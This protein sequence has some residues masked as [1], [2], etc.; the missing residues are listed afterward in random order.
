MTT[1]SPLLVVLVVVV[2]VVVFV[3]VVLLVRREPSIAWTSIC[4]PSSL[5]AVHP[6][7]LPK[8]RASL[9]CAKCEL[10]IWYNVRIL[11]DSETSGELGV[12][13]KPGCK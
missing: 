3:V 10:R 9:N 12:V 5:A 13:V 2:V 7:A 8:R 11:L 4:L 6:G 1:V